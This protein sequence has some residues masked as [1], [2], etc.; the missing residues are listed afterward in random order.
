ME[1]AT[2][3]ES[4]TR[5]PPIDRA[6]LFMRSFQPARTCTGTQTVQ[7]TSDLVH[8]K[9]RKKGSGGRGEQNLGSSGSA[10]SYG[11]IR[12]PLLAS[13]DEELPVH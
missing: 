1:K 12:V 3:S 4:E 9:R 2:Q 13:S 11:I 10:S 7:S 5:R 6:D 8:P